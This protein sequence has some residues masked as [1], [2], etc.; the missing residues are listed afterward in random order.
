MCTPTFLKPMSGDHYQKQAVNKTDAFY[1]Y[2]STAQPPMWAYFK[3]NKAAGMFTF[4][5]AEALWPDLC[6]PY[7]TQKSKYYFHT[8]VPI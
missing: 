2:T 7:Y 5:S 1:T 4:V 8:T 6:F 3:I